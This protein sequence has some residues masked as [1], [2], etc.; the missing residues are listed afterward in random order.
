M[1]VAGL[2]YGAREVAGRL[3][4]VVTLSGPVRTPD[5]AGGYATAI[6]PLQPARVHAS[7][8]ALRGEERLQAAALEVSITHRVLIRWHPQVTEATRIQWGARVL[9]V[10]G[11]PAE[12]GRRQLLE[13]LAVERVTRA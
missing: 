7:I 13:C 3:D 10:V 4:Q 5:G 11:P 12:I 6:G 9:E 2:R 1:S 8:D